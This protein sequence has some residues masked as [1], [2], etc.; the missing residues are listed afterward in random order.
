M[1]KKIKIKNHQNTYQKCCLDRSKPLT[2][3]R[4]TNRVQNQK[5]QPDSCVTP[6]TIS[7]CVHSILYNNYYYLIL[8]HVVKIKRTAIGIEFSRCH[9]T[10]CSVI[11]KRKRTGVYQ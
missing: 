10:D 2:T 4:Y 8:Y 11:R 7:I 5:I 9:D 3:D 1:E 6:N